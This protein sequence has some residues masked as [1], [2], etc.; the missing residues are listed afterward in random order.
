VVDKNGSDPISRRLDSHHPNTIESHHIDDSAHK[1][2][3][4]T[5]RDS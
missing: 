1:K 3:W 2:E 4:P 5:E